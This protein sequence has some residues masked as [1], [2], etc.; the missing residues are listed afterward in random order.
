MTKQ[1]PR[2]T[3]ALILVVEDEPRIAQ[4]LRDVL[5]AGGYGVDLAANGRLALDKIEARAYDL[6]I[7]DL[8]MPALDGVGLYREIT[9]RQPELLSR[10]LF[11]S[12]TMDAP[13][14]QRFLVE[15]AVPV[16]AKPFALADL[17]R[18]TQHVLATATRR[19]EGG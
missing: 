5:E 8:R 3:R 15:S 4:M 17:Y 18:L 13:E 19:R 14:Y 16:L 9:R 1:R 2:R 6:I 7:S 10:L 12:G 11:V